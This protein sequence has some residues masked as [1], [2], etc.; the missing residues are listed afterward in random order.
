MNALHSIPT[1]TG[2]FR[3]VPGLLTFAAVLLLPAAA[4]AETDFERGNLL[5]E[6]RQYTDAAKAYERSVQGGVAGS[7]LYFNL[8]NAYLRADD[9]GR[10]VLNYQRA[11]ALRP[12]HPEAAANLAFV[13][14]S[15][16]L[17]APSPDAWS[18]AFGWVGVDAWSVVAAIGMWALLAGLLLAFGAWPRVTLGWSLV[19]LG[20]AVFG[21][22]LTALIGLRGGTRDAAR[23]IVVSESGTKA[24]YAPADNSRDVQALAVGSEIRVLQDR[25]SWTYAELAGGVR[26]W[27]TSGDLERVVPK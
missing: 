18:Q 19:V 8:G 2:A 25:G 6:S 12:A 11:L 5:Y 1:V 20:L 23:A 4:S 21:V 13:R 15:L 24:H 17:A 26:G 7:N 9:Q 27:V 22:G 3:V 14:R 10:A 16:N